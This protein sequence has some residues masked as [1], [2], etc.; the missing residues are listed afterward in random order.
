MNKYII[1]GGAGMLGRQYTTA[2]LQCGSNVII[3]DNK[4]SKKNLSWPVGC[5]SW[6]ISVYNTHT[7]THHHSTI[8]HQKS[9]HAIY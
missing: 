3:L 8:I 4:T 2:L 7:A 9:R 1:T 6:I 5:L